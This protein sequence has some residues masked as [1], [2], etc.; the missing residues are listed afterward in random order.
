MTTSCYSNMGFSTADVVCASLVKSSWFSRHK[1][2]DSKNPNLL[3]NFLASSMSQTCHELSTSFEK[4]SSEVINSSLKLLRLY[5]YT[6]STNNSTWCSLCGRG[7]PRAGSYSR[8]I[9]CPRGRPVGTR[10]MQCALAPWS[11]RPSPGRK[12]RLLDAKLSLV[13]GWLCCS[14]FS[15]EGRL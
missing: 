5:L 10:S 11:S 6:Y 13:S 3:C 7:W 14:L 9:R 1:F 15:R 12:D 4:S 2:C 8:R